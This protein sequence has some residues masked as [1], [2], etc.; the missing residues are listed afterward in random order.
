M[1][2][3]ALGFLVLAG[4]DA[5]LDFSTTCERAAALALLQASINLA[6]DLSDGDCDYLQEPVRRAPGTQ[7]LLQSLAFL[8]LVEQGIGPGVLARLTGDIV[9]AA[10]A[11]QLEVR[12][13]SWTLDAFAYCADGF[14]ARPCAGYLEVIWSSTSLAGRA[15]DIGARLGFAAHV[16]GDIES[17][18]R[19]FESLTPVERTSLLATALAHISVL[20]REPLQC[21]QALLRNV[22]PVIAARACS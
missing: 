2:R 15:R 5:K 19:R 10:S 21:V 17:R 13:Q 3:G 6:D 1:P 20:R 11:Q 16:A 22:E 4:E 9:S 7:I 8:H 14:A 18:D 12:T